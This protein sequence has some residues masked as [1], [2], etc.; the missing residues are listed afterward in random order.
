MLKTLYE[1]IRHDAK[2]EIIVVNNRPY[3]TG[4]LTPVHE[5][6]VETLYLRTLRGLVDYINTNVDALNNNY[7]LCHV[8]SHNTVRL[9]SSID[10][11]FSQRSCYVAVKLDTAQATL[12]QFMDAEAFNI[13]LQSCFVEYEDDAENNRKEVLQYSSSVREV[14]EGQTL[15]DGITQAVTVKQGLASMKKTTIPNPVTLRPYRTFAEVEQPAS[16]FIFRAKSGPSF[17]LVEADGGAWRGEAMQNIKNF[18]QDA[19]PELKIIA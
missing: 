5:P 8:E 7:L 10:P 19:L 12:N 6:T 17:M 15:D 13:M 14:A 18:L 2:P 3:A 1:A 16:S 11:D 9:Y 4:E